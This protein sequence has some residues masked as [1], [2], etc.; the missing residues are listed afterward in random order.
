MNDIYF[1][2]KLKNR[3]DFIKSS[4]M[5]NY[6]EQ[7]WSNW[8][9]KCTISEVM[10]SFLNI[11]ISSKLWIFACK[12]DHL[13]RIGAIAM[14]CDQV[15]RR[16]PFLICKI[17]DF[18]NF[19]YVQEDCIYEQVKKMIIFVQNSIEKGNLQNF[20]EL[21][22]ETYFDDNFSKNLKH[23]VECLLN[24]EY[25]QNQA[26]TWVEISNLSVLHIEGS[27][28]CSLFNRVFR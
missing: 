10:S 7:F 5:S 27:L 6:E 25:N 17:Y 9:N 23:C 20:D 14:S 28:N 11:S 4:N 1:Y 24:F 26:S 12:S 2:G 13:F 3:R 19:I 21:N 18:N 22:D 15:D 8:L 16:Y